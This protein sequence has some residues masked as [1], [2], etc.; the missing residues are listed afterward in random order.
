M[1]LIEG[2]IARYRRAFDY[3]HQTARLGMSDSPKLY[4]RV[5]GDQLLHKWVL[6]TLLISAVKLF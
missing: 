5:F 4:R 1:G 6:L 2:F 3:Y